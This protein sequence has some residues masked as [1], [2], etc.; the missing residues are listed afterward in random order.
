VSRRWIAGA[1]VVLLAAAGC[2]SASTLASPHPGETTDPKLVA[3]AALRPCPTSSAVAISGGLPNVTLACL[4][5][6]PSVHLA[7]LTGKPTVVN[8]WGSWCGPCQTEEGYLSSAYDQVKGKVRF[9]GVDIEDSNDSALD[10]DAHVSPPVHYPSV[11]DPDKAV[12][13]GLHFTGPPETV[14]VD[15]TGH[16]VHVQAGPY[17]SRA[18]VTDDIAKYLH[19]KT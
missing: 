19:V 6:G 12:L 2:Q 9:L 18:A 16:V 15:G 3:A 8:L 14:F 4:G 7:G 13:N 5:H 11:I 1:G 17:L 10:F